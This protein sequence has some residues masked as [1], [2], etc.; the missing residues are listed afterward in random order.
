MTYATLLARN[1]R[2]N[3]LRTALTASSIMLSIFLVCAVL[4]LPN[5][6]DSLI[7]RFAS[8]TRI[9]V[10]NKAG[11]A[12]ALPYSDVQK[13]RAVPGVDAV[14]SFTWFGG[15]YDEPKNLFPNFAVDA[16]SVGGVWPDYKIDPQALADFRRYRD[17]AL[18]GYQTMDKFGWKVGQR[19][20]L[21]GTAWPVEL[22]FRIVGTLPEGSGNPVWF[23]F[24][25]VYLEQAV[26]AKG[27]SADVAGLIW[28]RVGDPTEIDR[29]MHRIDELFRNSDAETSSET[30]KSFI[31]GFMSSLSGI[32]RIM[33]AVGFLAVAAVVFIAAN[34]CSMTIRE[35]AGEIALLKALGFRR[36]PILALLLGETLGLAIVGGVV[37]AGAAYG[38]LTLL[39]K[40]G[41]TGM[42]RALGPLSMFRIDGAIVAEGIALS[43]VI[44]VIA[45]VIPSWSAARKPVAIAIRDVF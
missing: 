1:L 10:H 36:G 24:S 15:I 30:E 21:R 31:Q 35:R 27:Q 38:I 16:D 34:T 28:A 39:A 32:T 3:R 42:S 44:G 8:A 40:L 9:S 2:R 20:T 33:L 14:T 25:R 7:H 29:V 17:A 18:V 12:Y 41:A 6:L 26:R 43:F 23:L 4:T 45:G 11:L 19:V 22:D 5:G 13:I 37:G